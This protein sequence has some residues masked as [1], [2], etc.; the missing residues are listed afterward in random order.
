MNAWRRNQRY[1][2]KNESNVYEVYIYRQHRHA[3]KSTTC[4]KHTNKQTRMTTNPMRSAAVAYRDEKAKSEASDNHPV[5]FW[6][7]LCRD[8][9][10]ETMRRNLHRLEKTFTRFRPVGT[11]V[12]F[13]IRPSLKDAI[14]DAGVS[15]SEIFGVVVSTF[16]DNAVLE[17]MFEIPSFWPHAKST[18]T[19]AGLPIADLLKTMEAF[20]RGCVGMPKNLFSHKMRPIVVGCKHEVPAHCQWCEAS[21]LPKTIE[22]VLDFAMIELEEVDAS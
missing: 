22:E 2:P 10:K 3:R 5:D 15:A 4:N 8:T 18:C 16:T 19:N 7:V 14:R 9:C 12:L 21:P 17:I 1:T 13:L 6:L 20:P 11:K